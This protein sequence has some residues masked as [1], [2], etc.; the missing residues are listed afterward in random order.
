MQD[1]I[2]FKLLGQ[3][4]LEEENQDVDARWKRVQFKILGQ[5]LLKETE[6]GKEQRTFKNGNQN[7][8]SHT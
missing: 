5:Q 7:Q 4:L 3:Q 8:F 2:E 1:K 6:L